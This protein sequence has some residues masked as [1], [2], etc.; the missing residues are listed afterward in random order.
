[1][2]PPVKIL[3][4]DY[5]EDN[6]FDDEYDS[7]SSII[8]FEEIIPPV[9]V[10]EE[11]SS[12]SELLPEDLVDL[13]VV[14]GDFLIPPRVFN[15]IAEYLDGKDVKT[16]MCV[17][18]ELNRM[19]SASKECMKK[20]LLQIDEN[21]TEDFSGLL[22]EILESNRCYSNVE[23]T[24]KNDRISS[25]K[26]DRILKKFSV[27]ILNLKITKIGGHNAILAKPLLLF[28]LEVLELNVVCGRVSGEFLKH[29]CTLKKLSVNGLDPAA[30]I[31]CIQQN[32][33]LEELVLYEN[34]FICYFNEEIPTIFANLKKIAVYDHIN[35]D[36][37]LEGEF[38]ASPW[39]SKQRINFQ[40][41][42]RSHAGTLTSLHM[43]ICFSEDLDRFIKDLPNLKCLE[44]TNIAGDLTKIRL[45]P[46]DTITSFITSGKINGF[47]LYAIVTS[48]KNLQSMFV[49][50]V[51]KNH[52]LF[53]VRFAVNLTT[54]GY[55]W[56]TEVDRPFGNSI[57]LKTLYSYMVQVDEGIFPNID[58]QVTKKD[59]FMKIQKKQK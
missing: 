45:E 7:D 6:L 34:S 15:Q 23:I 25:K 48:C 17:N 39:N 47:L 19:A 36:V 50:K 38:P 46:N 4:V 13:S 2:E 27:S 3:R 53:I 54:F 5:I 33:E 49:N 44:V 26:I 31:P 29:V 41:F 57:D 28:S 59:G 55:F 24:M 10:L 21:K 22:T 8:A 18:K 40:K 30:L 37:T 1:M 58:V 12:E 56:A 16:V 14:S 42:L 52:F 9:V 35:T 43:D 20:L 11:S 32:L 51:Q